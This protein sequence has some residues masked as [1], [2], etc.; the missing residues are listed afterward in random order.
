[1]APR[2]LSIHAP[3]AQ[4]AWPSR[5]GR[6]TRF[7]VIIATLKKADL[8]ELDERLADSFMNTLLKTG[9]D[10]DL[11]DR[12]NAALTPF[13]CDNDCD[14]SVQGTMNQMA[15]DLDFAFTHQGVPITEITGYRQGAWLAD[16]PCTVKGHKDCIW[17][18]RTMRELLSSRPYDQAASRGCT[19]S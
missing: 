14:R 17:P 5:I 8:A 10:D 13:H 18:L 16:R 15:Q 3:K 7:P 12:A 4:S 2:K 1:M 19:S 11:M 6:A 9:A